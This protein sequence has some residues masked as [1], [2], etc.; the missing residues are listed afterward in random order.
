[1][2]EAAEIFNP[3]DRIS[4]KDYQSFRQHRDVKTIESRQLAMSFPSRVLGV[5]LGMDRGQLDSVR[6]TEMACFKRSV[7]IPFGAFVGCR[8]CI[9]TWAAKKAT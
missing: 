9:R 7:R 5:H 8:A 2:C 6:V 3:P 1:M 4:G